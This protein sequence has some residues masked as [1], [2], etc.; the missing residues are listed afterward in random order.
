[1]H[2][3]IY[4]T[5]ASKAYTSYIDLPSLSLDDSQL[6]HCSDLAS[7]LS[8]QQIPARANHPAASL[9]QPRGSAELALL[10]RKVVVFF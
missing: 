9:A 5:F 8:D 4:L 10:G 3:P 6:S 7:S 2:K 1:M